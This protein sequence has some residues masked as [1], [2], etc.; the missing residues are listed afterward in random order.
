ML[1]FVYFITTKKKKS[2]FYQPQFWYQVGMFITTVIVSTSFQWT[3]VGKN[4][5]RNKFMLIVDI[6]KSNLTL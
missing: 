6:S 3:E 1:C 2:R 4:V 5:L